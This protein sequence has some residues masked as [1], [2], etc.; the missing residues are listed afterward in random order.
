MNAVLMGILGLVILLVATAGGII[1]WVMSGNIRKSSGK[2]PLGLALVSPL[3]VYFVYQ[4]FVLVT[5]G[6]DD[7]GGFFWTDALNPVVHW[8]PIF[9]AW[10]L[11]LFVAA[12]V[13]WLV[14]RFASLSGTFA[15]LAANIVRGIMAFLLVVTVFSMDWRDLTFSEP[16]AIQEATFTI[17][18]N[19]DL[20]VTLDDTTP[21]IDHAC[22]WRV[23]NQAGEPVPGTETLTGCNGVMTPKLP[24][25][26]TYTFELSVTVGGEEVAG[27][28]RSFEVAPPGEEPKD[29]DQTVA[30]GCPQTWVIQNLENSDYRFLVD[31]LASIQN[32]YANDSDE[33]AKAAALDWMERIKVD[34][35]LMQ[36]T[37]DLVLDESPRRGDLVSGGC[38][39]DL[40]GAYRIKVLDALRDAAVTAEEAPSNGVNTGYKDGK[41]VRSSRQGVTGDRAAIKV[42]LANGQSFW[43]LGRCGQWVFVGALPLDLP[44]GPTDEKEVEAQAAMATTQPAPQSSSPQTSSPPASTTPTTPPATTPVPPAPATGKVQS[45]SVFTPGTTDERN[46]GQDSGGTWNDGQMESS[47]TPAASSPQPSPTVDAPVEEVNNGSEAGSGVS[48]SP[49]TDWS[50]CNPDGSNC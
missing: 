8:T 16:A 22:N 34:P 26:G 6:R 30:N 10:G 2:L 18:D 39:S 13:L 44:E 33:E 49:G 31:G 25:A 12:F 4:L 11:V 24:A 5:D 32:A 47:S 46:Q 27:S 42:E 14:R 40:A 17:K 19:G 37:I 50:G 29:P 7:R 3:F 35:T 43:I 15:R 38:A 23:L 1:L 21:G 41:I 20:T 36:G 28:A 45:D 9:M 48:D